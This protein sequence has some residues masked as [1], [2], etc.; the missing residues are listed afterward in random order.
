MTWMVTK[1]L[2]KYFIFWEF[3]FL[4]DKYLISPSIFFFHILKI[5]LKNQT[6]NYSLY[7]VSLLTFFLT[8][9]SVLLS[10]YK[11]KKKFINIILIP[12]LFDFDHC[13]IIVF[14]LNL[15]CFHFFWSIVNPHISIIYW[16]SLKI[17]YSFIY[18]LFCFSELEICYHL[19]ETMG[20]CCY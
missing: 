20:I 1:R 14:D 6:L 5:T 2:V 10:N 12:D 16:Q 9:K 11:K 19:L 15:H 7:W 18:L 8:T 3:R 4:F 17:K 13:Y